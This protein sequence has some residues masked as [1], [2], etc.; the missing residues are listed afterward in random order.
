MKEWDEFV[1]M[2]SVQNKKAGSVF[3][4]VSKS[5][6]S[7]LDVTKVPRKTSLYET[8]SLLSSGGSCVMCVSVVNCLLHG[9][10]LVIIGYG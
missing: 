4:P 3:N 5:L 8:I 10:V 1:E 6:S 7:W 9:Y 2:I